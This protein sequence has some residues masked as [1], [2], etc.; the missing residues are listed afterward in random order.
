MARKEKIITVKA[1]KKRAIARAT[2][3]QGTGSVLINSKPLEIVTPDLVQ[4]MISEPLLLA[5]E[6]AAGFNIDVN[7]KGGG[8]M[9]QAVAARGAIAKAIV[10]ITKDDKI[11]KRYLEY[12]RTLLVDDSRRV[13]PKK[14]LGRGA[15]STRQAS[16]R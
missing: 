6:Y 11:K 2:A 16:K 9:G 10:K 7:V 3:V 5:P 14:P 13:E 15:R 12:D 4:M 8:L 1:K